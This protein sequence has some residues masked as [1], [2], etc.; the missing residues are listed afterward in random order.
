MIDKIL[1]WI[2][3]INVES[4]TNEEKQAL[5]TKINEKFGVNLVE[6]DISLY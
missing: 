5:L 6:T 3:S 4:L 1:E 2:H